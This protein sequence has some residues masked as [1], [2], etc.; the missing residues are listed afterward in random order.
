M[1]SMCIQPGLVH[2][3]H[4]FLK[5]DAHWINFTWRDQA[6]LKYTSHVENIVYENFIA[7]TQS[8]Q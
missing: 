7:L 5:I 1:V 3:L 2:L 6:T 4:E 8:A